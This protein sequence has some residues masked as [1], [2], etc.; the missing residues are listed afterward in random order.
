MI[1]KEHELNKLIVEYEKKAEEN[2][3]NYQETGNGRY[4]TAYHKNED[5]ADTLKVARDHKNE[6]VKAR[7]AIS[8]IKQWAGTAKRI[9][10]CTPELRDIEIKNLLDA[11]IESA[12]W[13]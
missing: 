10:Y 3:R 12:K 4:W 6:Y 7:G 1:L 2:Y 8:D 5:M 9:P 11:I 13:L